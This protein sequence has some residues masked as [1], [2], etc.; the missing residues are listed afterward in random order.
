MIFYHINHS[1]SYDFYFYKY[2]LQR[3]AYGT[4]PLGL[5]LTPA[6]IRIQCAAQVSKLC[7]IYHLSAHPATHTYQT[8]T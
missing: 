8:L 2:D 6:H 7:T 5:W 4:L 1:S 3:P